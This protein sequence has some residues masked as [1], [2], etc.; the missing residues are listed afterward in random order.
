MLIKI[1][2]IADVHIR[3][4][5]RHNEYEIVFKRLYKTLKK[6]QVDVIFVVGD[7]F[8]SKT[9]LSPESVNLARTF[10]LNLS[11]IATVIV[12]P[13][14]HDLSVSNLDRMDAITPIIS[15]FSDGLFVQK[16]DQ[17]PSK[18][19]LY[20]LPY[21]GNYNIDVAGKIINIA[22]FSILDKANWKSVTPGDIALY[23]GV[24]D[25]ASTETGYTFLNTGIDVLFFDNH[26]ITLLGDIHKTQF[27]K[28]NIAYC[29]SLICQNF[30]EGV[31]R[32]LLI[33]DCND[34]LSIVDVR[35]INIQ[36]DFGYYTIVL[37][38]DGTYPTCSEIPKRAI[39]RIFVREDRLSAIRVKEIEAEVKKKFNVSEIR[40][41]QPLDKNAQIKSFSDIKLSVTSENIQDVAIQN[42][43]IENFYSQ[44]LT[45]AEL[46]RLQ[47]LNLQIQSNLEPLDVVRNV[48]WKLK[49]VSFDNFGCFKENNEIDFDKITG[50]TGIIGMNKIGK[51]TI[52]DAIAYC[53]FKATAVSSLN[54]EDLLNTRKNKMKVV[55]EIELDDDTYIITRDYRVEYG[56][57]RGLKK[58]IRKY[59]SSRVDF[60][61][62]NIFGDEVILNGDDSRDTETIIRSIFGTYENFK[63]TSYSQQNQS[64]ELIDDKR[65]KEKKEILSKFL[66]L[67]I[68]SQLREIAKQIVEG[69]EQTIGKIDVDEVNKRIKELTIIEKEAE[70]HKNIVSIQLKEQVD[71]KVVI[72]NAIKEWQDQIVNIETVNESVTDLQQALLVEQEEINKNTSKIKELTSEQKLITK[73]LEKVNKINQMYSEL[74]PIYEEIQT[75][76]RDLLLVEH[77][78]QISTTKIEQLKRMIKTLSDQPWCKDRRCIFLKDAIKAES[79]LVDVE[80]IKQTQIQ[81]K[82]VLEQWLKENKKNKQNY[83]T[84]VSMQEE[85]N[86]VKTRYIEIQKE[87]GELESDIKHTKTEMKA[88]RDKIKVI[89]KNKEVIEKNTKI[90]SC[91]SIDEDRLRV[92]DDRINTLSREEAQKQIVLEQA[93][94]EQIVLQNKIK[95]FGELNQRY[96]D[97]KN[98]IRAVDVGGIPLIIIKNAI[99]I[100]NIEI[101]KL[102]SLTD[103]VVELEMSLNEEEIMTYLTD[104]NGKRKIETASGMEKMMA[105]MAIRCALISLSSLSKPNFLIIDEGFGVLDSDNLNNVGRLF[106][107]MKQQFDHTIIISHVGDINDYCNNL[108]QVVVDDQGFSFVEKGR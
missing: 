34:D 97:L 62:K 21:S 76:E 11:S 46:K 98:Y 106:E 22:N 45:G 99:P 48:R 108:I 101:N 9:K 54:I 96:M 65:A 59:Q 23:H 4:T 82:K 12:T 2:H 10:F 92:T 14:N 16:G 39:V 24:V 90:K 50:V 5:S 25:Q 88:T 17:L 37:K 27:I 47:D 20:Y 85:M 58:E 93:Q 44:N 13:G 89:E 83:K 51:S 95:E 60:R 67:D 56:Q 86:D 26:K 107:T 81:K 52:V 6:E 42:K 43:Y 61:K 105:N 75:K 32:G 8:H 104:K 55:V 74:R 35:K 100:I 91:I 18:H 80:K 78:E 15:Y 41:I 29:G 7:I 64:L 71:E 66:G 79:D 3:N 31:D 30:S 63:L 33:W 84:I 28:R 70:E 94:L 38:E 36:N 57:K 72:Q 87:N 19:G 49:K 69:I 40:S 73:R 53:I 103:F 1:A 102:L 68:F 77:E